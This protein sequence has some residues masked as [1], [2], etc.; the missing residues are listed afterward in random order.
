M[1]WRDRVAFGP[2]GGGG[3]SSQQTVTNVQQIPQFE[4][5]YAHE[6]QNL[7]RSLAAQPYPVYQGQL[8]AGF[9]PTQEAGQTMAVNAA[10]SYQPGLAAANA[11]TMSALGQ[12]PFAYGQPATDAGIAGLAGA[13]GA[14]QPAIGAGLN[15]AGNALNWAQPVIG[16][17]ASMLN[18]AV[19]YGSPL[20]GAGAGALGGALGYGQ[21]AVNAGM[22]TIG[23]AL[24]Q[25]T[26]NP[27]VIQAHM[28]PYVQAAL[29]PQIQA[30]NEQL[31]QQQLGIDRQASQANAFGD[32]RHGAAS[33]LANFYGNQNMAGLLGQGYNTAFQNAQQ[34]A[35]QQQ[36]FGL[37]AGQTL[38][39][40][41][42]AQTGAATQVGQALGSLGLGQTGAATQAG[43]ALGNLGLGQAGAANSTGQTLANIGL[44]QTNA[45]SQIGQALANIGMGQTGQGIQEQQLGLQGGQQLGSLA[46][47]SQRL[48]LQGANAVYDIGAQQQQLQQ[49][50]LNLAYQQY[51]NQVQWPYQNLNTRLSALS[52]SPY[53]MTNST[54]LPQANQTASNLGM[55]SSLAGLLGGGL[56][57][58]GSQPPFGGVSYNPATAKV[59]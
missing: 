56:S 11:A 40:L 35:Q 51:Q 4:Q 30:L 26:A 15:T 57:G 16:S 49:Q 54:T 59:G 50:A 45:G 9:N 19:G 53:N 8:V 31:G 23:N 38:G 10:N 37:Q 18:N 52:N 20:T 42:L 47:M 1:W 21:N 7:A 28:S 34:A 43:Q 24:S 5:D 41:G 44:G 29:Q 6:N 36:Q 58:G 27:G 55:F 17:G 46:D 48:G 22:G 13:M 12:N 2:S 39:N 32:A 33:A 14:G 3:G 25:N